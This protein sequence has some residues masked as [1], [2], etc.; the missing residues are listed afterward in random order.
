LYHSALSLAKEFHRSSSTP[1]D[2]YDDELGRNLIR[3][4]ASNVHDWPNQWQREREQRD[5]DPFWQPGS[6]LVSE[7]E[8][9][10]IAS[11]DPFLPPILDA[12]IVICELLNTF[13]SRV[14]PNLTTAH[15]TIRYGIR[16]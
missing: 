16:P 6:F 5:K 7:I 13:P 15:S 9:L 11:R 1:R 4:I 10:A 14:F 3:D 12:R 8:Q 2:T